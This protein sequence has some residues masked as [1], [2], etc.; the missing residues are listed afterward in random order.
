V[1]YRWA[2]DYKSNAPN[3][4]PTLQPSETGMGEK[5]YQRRYP[6]VFRDTRVQA[7]VDDAIDRCNLIFE[8]A[9]HLAKLY[10]QEQ[11]D[12]H[13]NN[14]GGVFTHDVASSLASSLHLD[15][16]FFS[17]VLTVTSTSD[18]SKKKGPPFKDKGAL[19]SRLNGCYAR[20]AEKGALPAVKTPGTNLSHILS[21]QTT[22]LQTAYTNNIFAHYDAYVKRFVK[23]LILHKVAAGN[24]TSAG[25][26]QV[27]R[28]VSLVVRKLLYD[29]EVDQEEL[30]N[31]VGVTLAS[32]FLLLLPHRGNG[33]YLHLKNHPF[34][35]L[36]Y[37]IYMNN[38]TQHLNS[39][40]LNALPL[41][42]DFIPKHVIIDTTALLDITICP[43]GVPV[44]EVVDILEDKLRLRLR[45]PAGNQ[46][47]KGDLYKNPTTFV[48]NADPTTFHA[49][50]KTAIWKALTNIG[51]ER[52][53]L[54]YNGLVFNNLVTT[55]GYKVDMHYTT[56]ES[57]HKKPFTKG[58]K[59][60]DPSAGCDDFTYVH[61][62]DAPERAMLMDANLAFA[63][64]GKK[65]VLYITDGLRGGR[66]L[67]YTA[68]QR[69]FESRQKRNRSE[70]ENALDLR[71][72]AGGGM[73]YR[74]HLQTLQQPGALRASCR[75][76]NFVQYLV[77]RMLRVRRVTTVLRQRGSPSAAMAGVIGEAV[78]GG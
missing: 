49:V 53:P 26:K 38:R 41:R 63:D 34:D 54:E 50:F 7:K 75:C 16:R 52:V 44:G 60:K 17:T 3:L 30:V 42:T 1:I 45:T 36:P 56:E 51:T 32:N 5:V 72:Q 25:R 40:V 2:L 12:S 65:N 28:L 6:Q 73:T 14:N 22:Q 39:G 76:G 68:A 77:L 67:R 13:L 43:D 59:P 18:L 47:K 66:K 74:E 11:Y 21:Y 37:M 9:T 10:I 15:Q 58:E 4:I 71:D 33:R 8:T 19:A 64:P 35:H 46:L 62:L 20:Y 48:S 61:H 29:G 69:R 55:N 78:F 27:G 70:L 23:A 31:L 57:Y 24:L